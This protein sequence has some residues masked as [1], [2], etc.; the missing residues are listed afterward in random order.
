MIR[1]GSQGGRDERREA[2]RDMGESYRERYRGHVREAGE[3]RAREDAAGPGMAGR[4]E[5]YETPRPPDDAR[6]IEKQER[7]E[8]RG[9]KG[10]VGND[11]GYATE[12]DLSKHDWHDRSDDLV[13]A[14]ILDR[15]RLHPDLDTIRVLV[16]N[17]EV[18]LQGTVK[19]AFAKSVAEDI[20]QGTGG[21]AVVHNQL[22]IQGYDAQAEEMQ[23]VERT[24]R[25]S[26]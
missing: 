5:A 2:G 23:R 21:V 12:R 22:H 16:Q 19:S 18:T 26:S 17:T 20:A 25:Q 4:S 24:R 1:R 9:N 3:D 6:A 10:E 14:D 8:L 7:G 11:E 15:L 13:R